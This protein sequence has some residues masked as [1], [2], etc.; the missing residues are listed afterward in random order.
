VLRVPRWG[1]WCCGSACCQVSTQGFAYDLSGGLVLVS[2]PLV[3]CLTQVWIE[4]YG[5]RPRRS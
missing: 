4:P 5:K 3:E 2:R 1:G